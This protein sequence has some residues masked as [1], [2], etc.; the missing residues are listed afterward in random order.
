[1]E[2]RQLEYFV[3]VAEEASFT[4]A[5]ARVHVAQP[6]VSAQVRQLERELGEVLLDRSGRSVTLT[7]VGAA[8]LPYARAALAAVE[9]T[10]QAVAELTGLVRGHVA[11]GVVVSCPVV[12]LPDLLADFHQ[13]HPAVDITLHED[14]SD[15]LVAA[16]AGGDVD[17][18]I[19]AL[20]ED[21]PAGLDLHV[22]A[23]EPVTAAVAPGHELARHRTIP[24]AELKN[25][26]LI[27]LAR[28]TGLRACLDDACA[29]AGFQPRIAFEAG[30]PAALARLAARGLGVAILPDSGARADPSALHPLTITEPRLRGRMALAWR[31]GGPAS[32]AARVFT[33]LARDRLPAVR[34]HPSANPARG[35]GGRQSTRRTPEAPVMSSA[36]DLIE[37]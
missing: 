36:M 13:A 6:G 8:V 25:W 5:A 3:A 30:N 26:P 31:S 14:N 23:D 35:Q 28:G 10:R 16:V 12:D 9:G 1:M 24:L 2:L 15:R 34:P 33:G 29:A 11:V 37:R 18:A 7:E 4:R 17:V 27:S 20:T 21:D 19:I 22:I 32:P